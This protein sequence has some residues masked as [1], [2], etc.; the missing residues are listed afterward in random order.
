MDFFPNDVH[1][2]FQRWLQRPED[3]ARFLAGIGQVFEGEET[4]QAFAYADG[5]VKDL[6]ACTDEAELVRFIVTPCGHFV[7][8]AP[9]AEASVTF[10]S[11]L[12]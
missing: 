12:V 5:A 11:K 6:V 1:L 7:R 2:H 4:A 3:E 10:Q 9:L 8:V